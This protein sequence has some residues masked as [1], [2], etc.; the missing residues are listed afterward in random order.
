M[1]LSKGPREHKEIQKSLLFSYSLNPDKEIRVQCK[2]LC[3][4]PSL[5]TVNLM[6]LAPKR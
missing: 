5:I 2:Y 1:A 3:H 6:S 4:V